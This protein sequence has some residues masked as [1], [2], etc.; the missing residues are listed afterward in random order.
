MD[1]YSSS[2][3]AILVAILFFNLFDAVLTMIVLDHGGEEINPV[4]KSAMDV[5]GTSFWT[6]K[7]GLVSVSLVLLCLH[8]QFRRVKAVIFAAGLLYLMVIVYQM[9]L[10]SYC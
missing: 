3:F 10:I 5:F 9:V 1:R 8:S 2:L 7:F 4:V 6:W